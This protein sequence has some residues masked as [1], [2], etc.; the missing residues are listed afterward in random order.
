MKTF[1]LSASLTGAL[2]GFALR[3]SAQE[4]VFDFTQPETLTPSVATP[5]L[6]ESVELDGR[7]F[8]S[9]NVDVTFHA[10]GGGNTA[11]RLY[12]S[13]DA[14]CNLRVYDGDSFVVR[15][16][17]E[18]YVLTEIYFETALSGTAADVDLIASEGEYEW[19]TNTWTATAVEGV[20]EVEF[21]SNLQSRISV[22]K[23]TITKKNHSAVESIQLGDDA[24]TLYYTPD[25]R[26]ANR[27][28]GIVITQSGKKIINLH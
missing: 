4:S 27:P 5:G 7:T 24:F 25:G 17:N 13:Y 11:V 1:L 18:D 10:T 9:G 8:T 23:V 28:R 26:V 3:V 19:L 15:S 6:K 20:S 12:G 21:T 2:L 22:M 16:L 14:G